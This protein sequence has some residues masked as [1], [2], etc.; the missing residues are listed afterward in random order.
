MSGVL[1]CHTMCIFIQVSQTF[2]AHLSC[3]YSVLY[4]QNAQVCVGTS[5]CMCMF[6]E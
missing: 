1:Y 3:V 4:S 5:V 2:V 6:L